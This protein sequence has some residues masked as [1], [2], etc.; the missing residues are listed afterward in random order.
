MNK[1]TFAG[2]EIIFGTYFIGQWID[3]SG[4]IDLQEAAKG[5]ETNPFKAIPVFVKTAIETTAEINSKP[6]EISIFRV[7]ELIEAQ[8]G[9]LASQ[10]I[11][12]LLKV[13]MDSITAQM[14][15]SKNTTTTLK[16]K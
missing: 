10:E 7:I 2:Y 16:K 15:P 14:T 5:L 1:T 6:I 4:S 11:K 13:F 3:K 12:D 9:I 8:G